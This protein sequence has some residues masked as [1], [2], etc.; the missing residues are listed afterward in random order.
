[1][2]YATAG[3][4]FICYEEWVDREKGGGGGGEGVLPTV[5][6]ITGSSQHHGS[7]LFTV[8]SGSE[9]FPHLHCCTVTQ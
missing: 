8:C 3:G 9:C 1:M 7:P 5:N 2:P 4:E 6:R